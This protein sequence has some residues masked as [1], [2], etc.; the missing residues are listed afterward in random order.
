[1][2]VSAWLLLWNFGSRIE[3]KARS[4]TS[5]CVCTELHTQTQQY[6]FDIFQFFFEILLLK[7][8]E[9]EALF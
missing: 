5:Q 3:L 2:I 6:V 9:T 4:R 1:M 7:Q 8:N